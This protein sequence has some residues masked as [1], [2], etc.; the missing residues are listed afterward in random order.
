MIVEIIPCLSDNY[1]YLI[2]EKKTG[3]PLRKAIVW[4]CKRSLEI[5]EKLKKEGSEELIQRK[6]GLLLDPYFTGTK[7]KWVMNHEETMKKKIFSREALLG[8]VDTFLLYKLT[9]GKSF[10]TEHSNASR[11]LLYDIQTNSWDDEL[12]N[13]MGKAPRESLPK[14]LDSNSFFGETKGEKIAGRDIVNFAGITTQRQG[15]RQIAPGTIVRGQ[16][17][18]GAI[19]SS[20]LN[21]RPTPEEFDHTK[22]TFN[23]VKL[24]MEISVFEPIL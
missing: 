1:S 19:I 10:F 5:C 6:T 12:L 21:Q 9:G 16:M 17:D 7:L 18:K 3:N 14:V 8:T 24:I 11:T 23:V 2:F 15:A 22:D 4:Q 13:L 20:N